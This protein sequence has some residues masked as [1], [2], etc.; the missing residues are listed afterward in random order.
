MKNYKERK[1]KM[2]KKD[3]LEIRYHINDNIGDVLVRGTRLLA[4]IYEKR[5]VVV[6]PTKFKEAMED[7]KWIKA[8][9]EELRMIEIN[10]T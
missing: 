5:N 10:D 2:T 3:L 9:E 1:T 4:K 8:I 7:D 6:Q